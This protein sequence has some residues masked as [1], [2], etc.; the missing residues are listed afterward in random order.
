MSTNGKMQRQGLLGLQAGP[1]ARVVALSL[2]RIVIHYLSCQHTVI[3][4]FHPL[5]V[6]TEK[7][8][9]NVND[10]T[11]IHVPVATEVRKHQ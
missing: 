7:I 6:T 3:Y 4:N 10:T 11:V 5:K 9:N 1:R 2:K 8:A